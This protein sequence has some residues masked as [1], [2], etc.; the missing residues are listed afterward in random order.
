MIE[1]LD[2]YLVRYGYQEDD[3]YK[4]SNAYGGIGTI[5]ECVERATKTFE[6]ADDETH[7][8]TGELKDEI[9]KW[10]I[11]SGE[12]NIEEILEE[13]L[14]LRKKNEF[15]EGRNEKLKDQIHTG[16]GGNS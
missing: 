14:K 4:M 16:F 9:Y 12:I 1:E 11:E 6:W 8:Y 7:D 3:A 13:N 2:E 5:K 15:L 10:L